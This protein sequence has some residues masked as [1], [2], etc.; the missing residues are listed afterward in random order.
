MI[1]GGPAPDQFPPSDM[2]T[3]LVWLPLTSVALVSLALLVGLSLLPAWV[4]TILMALLILLFTGRM[5][6]RSR[7]RQRSSR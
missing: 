2:G 7:S 6:R 1:T 5:V 3:W 4:G